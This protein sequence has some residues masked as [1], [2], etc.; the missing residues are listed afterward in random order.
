MKVFAFIAVLITG[1]LLVM[2]V[3]SFPDWGDPQS[4][5]S[6]HVSPHYI[7]EAQQETAV[8]NIVTAVLAD[9]RGFDTM[10]ETAVIFTAGIAVML[11]LRVF[12]RRRDT[13][14]Q[15]MAP[16]LVYDDI[17]VRTIVHTPRF[18]GA[19]FGWCTRR[20]LYELNT[21]CRAGALLFSFF[22]F[23]PLRTN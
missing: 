12:T 14:P 1:V 6:R 2:A 23:R 11:I 17:I 21:Y 13:V 18:W 20:C 9:Y 15:E 10:F 22:D 3:Q 4:P 8:P 16:E 5:A 19:P 7:T